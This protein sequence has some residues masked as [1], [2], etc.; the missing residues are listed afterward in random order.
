MGR[1]N[2]LHS[3]VG[4]IVETPPTAPFPL[5]KKAEWETTVLRS[6]LTS[7]EFLT[8]YFPQPPGSG[9]FLG[10]AHFTPR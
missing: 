9:A 4:F 8:S 7:Y 5:K 6:F 1:D 2:E 3:M 10:S